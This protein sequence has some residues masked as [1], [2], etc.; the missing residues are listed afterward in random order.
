MQGRMSREQ[1]TRALPAVQAVRGQ[2]ASLIFWQK[3]R[4]KKVFLVIVARNGV[5]GYAYRS[6]M[7]IFIL[8]YY[9]IFLLVDLENDWHPTFRYTS[10]SC[11]TPKH[12][13]LL[14]KLAIHS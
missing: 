10:T 1:G 3:L 14:P 9:I 2:T 12:S 13:G 11:T 6:H 8:F 7:T 4:I 5:E